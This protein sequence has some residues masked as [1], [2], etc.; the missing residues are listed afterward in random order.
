MRRAKDDARNRQIRAL[1]AQGLTLQKIA[2]RYGLSRQRIHQVVGRS[3]SAP[4]AAAQAEQALG[5]R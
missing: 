5:T 2:D 4:T 3:Q 1:R